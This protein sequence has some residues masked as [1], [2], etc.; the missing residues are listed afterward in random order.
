MLNMADIPLFLLTTREVDP[1]LELL[2]HG[3]NSQAGGRFLSPTAGAVV[4]LP[5][6]VAALGSA[7]TGRNGAV[8]FRR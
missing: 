7:K 4:C 6:F 8:L 5:P 2:W 3:I 1:W